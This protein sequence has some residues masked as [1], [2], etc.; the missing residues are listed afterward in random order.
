MFL[1]DLLNPPTWRQT[2]WRI[3]AV[4]TLIGAG[5][6]AQPSY[7][8]LKSWRAHRMAEEAGRLLATNPQQAYEQ[9]QAAWNLAPGD[10]VCTRSMARTL[11]A[12]GRDDAFRYWQM[13][14]GR[15]PPRGVEREE[16]I[17]LA[18]RVKR[19]DLAE[20]LLA[21]AL[22]E[23]PRRT[24]LLRLAALRSELRKDP[25]GAL[26]F[27]QAWV[28]ADTNS[29]EGK[30][31]LARYLVKAGSPEVAAQ[32]KALLWQA[33][34]SGGKSAS[35]ALD[36]L[37]GLPNLSAAEIQECIAQMNL[38]PMSDP[39]RDLTIIDLHLRLEPDRKSELADAA[40]AYYRTSS[41][42]VLL[43]VSR[44]LAEKGEHTKALQI[45]LP[46]KA[47][48]NRELLLV[49][50][51]SL[52]ALRQ[53]AV[54]EELLSQPNLPLEPVLLELYRARVAGELKKDRQ[55]AHHWGQV[56]W[57]SSRQPE[58]LW[59]VARYAE[60]MGEVDQAE[61]AYRR[62]T[63]QPGHARQAWLSLIR[64]TAASK[65]TGALRK[66]LKEVVTEFPDEPV[67]LNDLAYLDLL[68]DQNIG[69]A[70]QVAQRL[71]TQDP[72]VLSFR[73]TLALAHLRAHDYDAA[74]KLYQDFS[75][76]WATVAP[77]WRAVY[78]AVLG[79]NGEVVQAREIAAT[80]KDEP[81]RPEER[82][83][84]DWEIKK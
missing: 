72:R 14:L 66:L 45:I 76:A 64:L 42:P 10:P 43:T 6:I 83:L 8:S 71:V 13:L 82:A 61:Y 56:Q 38:R 59:Y 74:K 65:D 63:E 80:L 44:W 68:T 70:S 49:T 55:K 53:W 9:A 20:E 36:M 19:I 25:A 29:F 2:A 46:Y 52:A 41:I 15:T 37:V 23:H 28:A 60:R 78:A 73:T 30:V 35:T 12:L 50:A 21:P 47:C 22:N 33:V 51:D 18:L 67:P 24:A 69:P 27:A 1:P 3:A 26:R 57:L 39:K 62:L 11:S 32:A 84:L 34:R 58:T 40:A 77:A 4:L 81:L 17:D 54:L 7:R 75:V 31:F 48:A 5:L 79:A 16:I